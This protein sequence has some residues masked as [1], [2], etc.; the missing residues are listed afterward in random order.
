MTHGDDKGL[1]LPPKI[2]PIQV[3]RRQLGGSQR[4]GTHARTHTMCAHAMHKG[5]RSHAHRTCV[6]AMHADVHSARVH[7][8]TQSQMHVHMC[9]HHP[10]TLIHLHAHAHTCAR[11]YT[12]MHTQ[13]A[14]CTHGPALPHFVLPYSVHSRAPHLSCAVCCPFPPASPHAGRMSCHIT[15]LV[16][17][18]HNCL[19]VLCFMRCPPPVR[20]P[21]PPPGS[22]RPRAAVPPPPPSR[23]S[24]SLWSRRR[25]SGSPSWRLLVAWSAQPKTLQLGSRFWPP[26]IPPLLPACYTNLHATAGL[27]LATTWNFSS[28]CT[29]IAPPA[30][31]LPPPSL[32]L[33]LAL[34]FRA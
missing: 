33:T 16:I 19:H 6:H 25:R 2:A 4:T 27:P 1:R 10:D 22:H 7:T 34:T 13:A 29:F 26:S 31:T 23:S 21:P 15:H 20:R 12:H 14:A 32:P 28:S 24:S 17:F 5:R 9:M 3:S 18:S 30:T 11:T 8:H